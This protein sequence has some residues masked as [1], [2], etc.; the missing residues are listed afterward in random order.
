MDL[1]RFKREFEYETVKLMRDAKIPGMSL[2]IT[3]DGET[4][5]QRAFGLRKKKD[6]KPATIDTL[7]GTSSIT[8]SVTSLAIMQ[9][10]QAGKLDIHAPI[11]DYLP[12]DIGFKDNPITSHHLMSHSSGVPAL[13]TF[14]FAQMNQEL[15]PGKTPM[16]PL[17]NWD[18]FYFHINEAKD[19]VIS[20]PGTK[21]Y[22]WNGAFA[23]LSQIIEKVSGKPY[24]EYVKENILLPLDMKRSTYSHKEAEQDGDDSRGFN[25]IWKENQ[26][27]RYPQDMLSSPFT[28]GSG[29][30]ISSVVEMTNYLQCFLN[31]G[32]FR[33]K[34]LLSE[35]LVQEMVKPHNTNITDSFHEYV[36]DVKLGYGYGWRVYENFHGN[37]LIA[38]RGVSGVTGGLI[39]YMPELNITFAQL[40]NVSYLPRILK[41]L[42]FI[43]LMGKEPKEVMPY[44]IR[45]KHY[46]DLCG[47]YEAF[48]K[49]LTIDVQERNG[50]LYLEGDFWDG[51]LSHPIIPKSKN[52]KV[53]E[54]YCITPY[55]NMDVN[56]TKLSSGEMTFE[57]ER[58]LMRKKTIEI[59]ED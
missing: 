22:Y 50:L 1:E 47:R 30:L 42:A 9:L 27:N 12:V 55:G 6:V 17:G 35:D 36:P 3:K 43:L 56:F 8:K 41:H 26:I 37:T 11:S 34:K 7:Y 23:L 29:G 28:A 54:F 57:Y 46:N 21:F 59:K 25:F 4:I 13:H 49:I 38:H 58:Y 2:L 16:I 44:Y 48:K 14:Y 51:R 5:Y 40:Y 45:R 31:N 20:P 39:G 24:E 15:Y 19:E 53:M 33:G 18:D 52:P 10:F 32:E